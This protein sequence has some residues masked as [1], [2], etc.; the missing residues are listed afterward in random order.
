[1]K[2]VYS[3]YLSGYYHV[4]LKPTHRNL[5]AFFTGKL[6][7]FLWTWFEEKGYLEQLMGDM[8]H[9]TRSAIEKHL[10]KIKDGV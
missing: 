1:M 10:S 5:R 9:H 7:L 6:G 3:P 2:N 4:F 8:N